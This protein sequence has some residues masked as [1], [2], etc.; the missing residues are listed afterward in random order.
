MSLSLHTCP[1]LYTHVLVF[2]HMSW[3][4]QTCPC[5]YTHV[6]VFTNMSLSLHT[7]WSLQTYPYLYTCHP[8]KDVLVFTHI[9]VFTNMFT[10]IL[11]LTNMS[12]SL[13]NVH[14]FK[15]TSLSLN[16]C[17]IFY[18]H[19]LVFTYMSLSLKICPFTHTSLS[20]HT[21]PCPCLIHLLWQHQVTVLQSNDQLSDNRTT[22]CHIHHWWT[23]LK[24]N[25]FWLRKKRHS[26]A[27]SIVWLV[28]LFWTCPEKR[29]SDIDSIRRDFSVPQ[30]RHTSPL[31]CTR[32]M[33]PSSANDG[34]IPENTQLLIPCAFSMFVFLFQCDTVCKYTECCIQYV[35]VSMWHSMQIHWVLHSVC[36]CFDAT[37][38]ANTLSVAFSM[39]VFRCDTVC[40]YIE[41]C[42]QYVCVSVWH[43]MKI[44][45]LAPCTYMTIKTM[46]CTCRDSTIHSTIYVYRQN[47]LSIMLT[48]R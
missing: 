5:L 47:N 18:I 16:I 9:L 27:W 39:F 17:P 25:W 44:R 22:C 3:S 30:S 45:H 14:V 23:F 4:L 40:K 2:T 29:T 34:K 43:S 41:C 12:L 32:R 11:V 46:H 13:H 24:S 28:Y 36:L 1:G 31:E 35:C 48:Y 15:Y 6:L 37:Q 20:S 33:P 19:L 21:C 10:H 38:Y 8:Y 7:S 26:S 42:I